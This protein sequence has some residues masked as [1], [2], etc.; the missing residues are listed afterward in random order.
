MESNRILVIDD[1][2]SMRQ[3]LEILLK[4]DGY[5]VDTAEN[6]AK[7]IE[8]LKKNKYSVILM[9][10]NMPEAIDG[11]DLLNELRIRSRK[12]QIIVI[13]AFA[14]TEQAIK[15]I[16]LGA[17]DY[18][19]KPFNVAEIRDI[20]KK[21]ISIE[22]DEDAHIKEPVTVEKKSRK[23]E[24]PTAEN[25][26]AESSKMLKILEIA[27]Q[28]APTD[29]TVLLTGDSGTGKEVVAR[30]I[31]AN[32]GRSNKPWYPVNCGA[33]PENLLES[34]LFGHEKGSFTGAY[35]MKKGYFEVAGDG[36]LFL[37][38]IG[39]LSENMQVKLLR[40]LQEKNFT[41]VGGTE[42]I[43]TNVRLIAATNRN[44]KE[45][46]QKGKF[47]EDLY[48]RLNVLELYIPP[49]NERRDD[50]LPLAN[51]FL[52]Q[53]S[54][55]SGVKYKFSKEL[56]DFFMNYPFPGN[57]RELKNI[58]E[59]GTV[60]AKDGLLTKTHFENAHKISEKITKDLSI[61]VSD[62]IDLDEILAEIEKK[63]IIA[64]LKKTDY[65]RHDTCVLLNISER[66]LRYRISKLGIKDDE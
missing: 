65:N 7:A 50:I 45:Q 42:K 51:F 1:E 53:F 33:I 37:D 9:D 30:Y 47:R 2:L 10:Y 55:K 3:F 17:V 56:I 35:Q 5:S 63:Y 25:V 59:R 44:L 29:S 19:S 39:E 31:H 18:V 38:E 26:V 58:I 34:E 14:S 40:V 13:T 20:V 36:T 16:E 57:V 11:I 66:S 46:M 49:L 61:D 43:S 41:R 52:E 8:M 6:G 21:C 23:H 27:K 4:K 32:S 28:I 22:A 60:F 24:S 62:N 12:S 64:A 54:R 48:F 15:A